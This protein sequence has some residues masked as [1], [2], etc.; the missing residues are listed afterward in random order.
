MLLLSAECGIV[1]FSSSATG[2][3][4]GWQGVKHSIFHF[5]HFA[6]VRK[7]GFSII[8]SFST[9]KEKEVTV[10]GSIYKLNQCEYI[11]H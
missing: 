5:K 9:E 10:R 7:T 3:L 4:E 2:E 11:A 1:F 6:I 8:A